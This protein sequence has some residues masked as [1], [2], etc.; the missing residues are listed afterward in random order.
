M[1]VEDEGLAPPTQTYDQWLANYNS[2][3]W[4]RDR[5][6]MATDVVVMTVVDGSLSVLLIR[7]VEWPEYG[8][9]VLP[10]AFVRFDDRFDD[11]ARRVLE[12]KAHIGDRRPLTRLNFFDHLERDPRTKVGSLAYLCLAGPA[13]V[14]TAIDEPHRAL[15]TV[16][17][18]KVQLEGSYITLGFDHNEI[19]SYACDEIRRR[20][21][22]DPLWIAPAISDECTFTVA[23]L[24]DARTA[25]GL[26]MT[27]DALRR[28]IAN[29][30]RV[31]VVGWVDTGTGK[32]SRLYR[33]HL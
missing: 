15:G 18:D 13:E 2:D 32:P 5:Q 21:Q 26:G 28:R 23:G 20:V 25:L 27:E 29:D 14:A 30:A 19:V 24:N 1:R 17:G 6:M 10:G 3:L 12:A 9:W 16:V 4:A 33:A 22:A 8:A 7:R 31:A 11:T